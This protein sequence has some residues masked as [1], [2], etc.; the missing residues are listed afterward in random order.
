M[1]RNLLREKSNQSTLLT[2]Q[3]I[4]FVFVF[5]F[6]TTT[7]ALSYLLCMKQIITHRF[8][9]VQNFFVS[10][11]FFIVQPLSILARSARVISIEY[12]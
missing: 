1:Q 11:A 2:L 9:L 12:I 7:Y 8:F 3:L 5:I 6:A 4:V 10:C